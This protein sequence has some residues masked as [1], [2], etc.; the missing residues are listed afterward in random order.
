MA[1][2]KE[3]LGYYPCLTMTSADAVRLIEQKAAAAFRKLAAIK[4]YRI[5]GPVEFVTEY[6]TR[7]TP[8]PL[9]PLPPGAARTGPRTIRISGA[10][11]LEAWSRWSAR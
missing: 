10:N 5:E 6:T 3:G 1:V 2:V 11:F 8:S 9:T 7:S 4:P